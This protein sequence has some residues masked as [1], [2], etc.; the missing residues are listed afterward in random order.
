[1]MSLTFI[2]VMMV[3]MLMLILVMIVMVMVVMMLMLIL[4]M[5]VVVMVMMVMV[6]LLVIHRRIIFE[7]L[8][9]IFYICGVLHR[10]QDLYPGNIIPCGGYHSCFRIMLPDTACSIHQLLFRYILG[11]AEYYGSCSFDLIQEELSEVLHID[12]CLGHIDNGSCRIQLKIHMFCGLLDRLYHIGKLSDSRGFDDDPVRV[13]LIYDLLQSL[14]EISHQR[15]ADAAGIQFIY[16]DACFLHESTVHT[17]LT[18]FI[19]DQDQLLSGKCF[20]D[21]FFDKCCFSGSQ[22]SGNDVYLSHVNASVYNTCFI[23]DKILRASHSE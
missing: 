15:A 6:M 11:T 9:D 14:T 23:F 13:I 3:M 2:L 5:I 7:I 1:M 20:L 4:I 19:L 12:L 10:L 17:D 16:L 21:Q 8:H 18:E 22:E